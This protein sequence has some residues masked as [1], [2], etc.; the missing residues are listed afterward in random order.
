M[1]VLDR[2]A[3]KLPDYTLSVAQKRLPL[4][5]I[6]KRKKIEYFSPD[7][8]AVKNDQKDVTLTQA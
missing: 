5:K 6:V 8:K 7:W 1:L 4:K 3:Y 2:I